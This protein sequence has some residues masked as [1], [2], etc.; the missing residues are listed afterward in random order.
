[1]PAHPFGAS[2]GVLYTQTNEKVCLASPVL[3]TCLTYGSAR[4]YKQYLAVAPFP[5]KSHSPDFGVKTPR[6]SPACIQIWSLAPAS[7]RADD[8]GKMKC[9]MVLCVN[10]GPAHELKWCPLPTHDSVSSI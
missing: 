10:S 5:S 3:L 2:T 8:A 4:S 6:P 7:G 9:E 1:M